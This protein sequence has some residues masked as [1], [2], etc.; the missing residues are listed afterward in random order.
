MDVPDDVFSLLL[1]GVILALIFAGCAIVIKRYF[2]D[3][4]YFGG[5][6]FVGREVYKSLQNA[7]RKGSVEHVIYMEED[8]SRQDFTGEDDDEPAHSESDQT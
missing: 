1:A 6:Q 3:K 4:K 2:I 5:S 7:D 8:E